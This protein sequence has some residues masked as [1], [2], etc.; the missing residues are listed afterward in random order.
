MRPRRPSRS[1]SAVARIFQSPWLRTFGKY[2]YGL[3]IFHFPLVG[4]LQE[5]IYR[6]YGPSLPLVL[7]SQ[8]PAAVAHAAVMV[9]GSSAV[10]YTS[11]HLY[12][13]PFLSLK[14]FFAPS[15]AVEV[16]P[17]AAARLAA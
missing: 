9:A 17:Q 1:P 4:Y 7:G 13:K 14:R 12:E 10:A 6:E 3:Y 15:R 5:A 11:F 16:V 8:I 2:S